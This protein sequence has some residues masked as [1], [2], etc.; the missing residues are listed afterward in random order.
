MRHQNKQKWHIHTMLHFRWKKRD[1]S[2]AWAD[3]LSTN[4][5][6]S[7]ILKKVGQELLKELAARRCGEDE[8]ADRSRNGD[9]CAVGS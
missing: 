8:Q 7:A 1:E 2:Q 3:F 5:W 4:R 9:Q 6:F